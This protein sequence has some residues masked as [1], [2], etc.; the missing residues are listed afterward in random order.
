MS[1]L[2]NSLDAAGDVLLAQF[3]QI[4]RAFSDSDVKGGHNERV[5]SEFVA[6]ITGRRVEVGVE[7][8]DLFGKRHS[9]EC[10]IAIC[11][12]GQPRFQM[13]LIA[14]GV[15]AVLQVKAS[16]NK[17]EIES[18]F[19]NSKSVKSLR[20]KFTNMLSLKNQGESWEYIPY[21]VVAFEGLKSETIT[22]HLKDKPNSSSEQEPDAIFVLGARKNED[23]RPD[24]ERGYV[25][26]NCR[27]KTPGVPEIT[28]DKG[29]LIN[30]EWVCLKTG[31][32]TL[33]EFGR[34]L[35]SLR[36]PLFLEPPLA[37]YFP[38]RGYEQ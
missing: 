34:A 5:I 18:I 32:N 21:Y 36:V 6:E 22:K 17:N 14:E 2:V 27:K 24:S 4:R 26:W 23:Q 10:D 12:E 37:K 15:D 29:E 8:F 38:R 30:G 11:N 33:L 3:V 16:L 35:H 31:R 19:K 13:P 20:R 1:K 7:I 9:A 28:D 25:L